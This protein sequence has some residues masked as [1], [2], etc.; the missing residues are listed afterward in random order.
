M[1][2]GTVAES[3]ATVCGI[4][5]AREAE[6]RRVMDV[7]PKRFAKYGLKVHPEKTRLVRFARPPMAERRAERPETFDFLG[8][9]HY[10]GKSHRGNWVLKRGQRQAASQRYLPLRKTAKPGPENCG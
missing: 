9:T 8:F 4:E 10:W 7:L 6:A 5:F 3:N 2:N 1:A